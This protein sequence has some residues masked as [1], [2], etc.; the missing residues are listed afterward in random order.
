MTKM[1]SLELQRGLYKTVEG[2]MVAKARFCMQSCQ[3]Q[4]QSDEEQG[5]MKNEDENSVSK[6]HQNK[7]ELCS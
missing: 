7:A 6:W 4:S 5:K 3:V 2:F 1:F